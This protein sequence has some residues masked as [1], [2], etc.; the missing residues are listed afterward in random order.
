MKRRAKN[1][2]ILGVCSLGIDYIFMVVFVWF[3]CVDVA[4]WLWSAMEPL[5]YGEEELLIHLFSTSLCTPQSWVYLRFGKEYKNLANKDIIHS[6]LTVVVEY[7]VNMFRLNN[8]C[9]N[10][11]CLITLKLLVLFYRLNAIFH[12]FLYSDEV[13][14]I[15]T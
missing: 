12:V 15:K 2:Y 8:F 1:G 6:K 10:I 11:S 13:E 4:V 14:L 7:G 3:G 5:E 9:L